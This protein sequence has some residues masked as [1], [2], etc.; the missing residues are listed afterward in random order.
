MRRKAKRESFGRVNSYND[1]G[2][3]FNGDKFLRFFIDG[4]SF[5]WYFKHRV[6]KY[7]NR[8]DFRDFKRKV[9]RIIKSYSFALLRS[10]FGSFVPGAVRQMCRD[11]QKI[12]GVGWKI[13]FGKIYCSDH[14]RV[15]LHRVWKYANNSENAQY[16]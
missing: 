3:L 2:R 16:A 4:S 7:Y 11:C 5:L 6:P 1:R 12:L 13:S 10:R 14:W 9:R 8:C 15:R